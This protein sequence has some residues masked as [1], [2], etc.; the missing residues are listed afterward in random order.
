MSQ[1]ISSAFKRFW[2][3]PAHPDGAAFLR[4]ALAVIALLQLAMLWPHLLSLY[5]NYGFIQWALM[6]S[7]NNA[8][9]PS[10]GKIALFIEPLGFSSAAVVYALFALYGASLVGLLVGYRARLFAV[11][12]WLTHS[13]TLNSGFFSLY[14]VDTMLH[15]L[16]FYLMFAPSGARWSLDARLGR[17]SS[18]PSSAAR[19]AQ[20]MIQLHLCLIYFN[21]GVAKARGM[22]W[23]DGE[24]IWRAMMMPQFNVIDMGWITAHPWMAALMGWSVLLVELGYAVFIWIPATR[25]LA[26]ASAILMHVG[27]GIAMRLWLFSLVMISFNLA[28]FGW[29]QL[30]RRPVRQGAPRE[31]APDAADETRATGSTALAGT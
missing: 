4:L 10:I 19:I 30:A 14:G 29:A 26:L 28:A 2:L 8:W 9:V 18:A 25:R 16:F 5:G 7:S 24:A 23:W 27:I 20:R 6:E 12:A 1:A 31:A 21:T 11:L 3:S 15:I 13:I 22:Q 17:V